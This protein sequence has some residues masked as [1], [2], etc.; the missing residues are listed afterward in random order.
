M[1]KPIWPGVTQSCAIDI[2][3]LSHG[4][5]D[6]KTQYGVEEYHFWGQNLTIL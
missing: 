2:V 3:N 4:K 1:Q 5:V 6:T